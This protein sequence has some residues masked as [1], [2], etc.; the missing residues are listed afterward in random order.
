MFTATLIQLSLA[1]LPAC[2]TAWMHI[3]HRHLFLLIEYILNKEIRNDRCKSRQV[4]VNFHNT[5]PLL[6]CYSSQPPSPP[7]CLSFFSAGMLPGKIQRRWRA[8][9]SDWL[10]GGR[11]AWPHRPYINIVAGQTAE[12]GSWCEVG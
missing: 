1:C 7:S 3:Q 12:L 5:G 4:P 9:L 6:L 2:L 10:A 8:S 11:W